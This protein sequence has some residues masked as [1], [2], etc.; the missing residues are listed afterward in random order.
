MFIYCDFRWS[1]SSFKAVPY[2]TVLYVIILTKKAAY[3]VKSFS[4]PNYQFNHFVK[5]FKI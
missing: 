2:D 1:K 5:Y 4:L 3:V